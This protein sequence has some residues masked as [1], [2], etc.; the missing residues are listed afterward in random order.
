M[1]EALTSIPSNSSCP[2]S[3]IDQGEAFRS[4]AAYLTAILAGIGTLP[5]QGERNSGEIPILGS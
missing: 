3:E 1:P 2:Q 4:P 5:L